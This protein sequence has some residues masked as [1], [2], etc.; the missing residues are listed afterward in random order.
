MRVSSPDGARESE[1]LARWCHISRLFQHEGEKADEI[2]ACTR[3]PRAVP[4]RTDVELVLLDPKAA[5][6]PV[7]L[8]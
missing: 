1:Y 4:D 2:C 7:E 5:R 8:M 6:R 3:N